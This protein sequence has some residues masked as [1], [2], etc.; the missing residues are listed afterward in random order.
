M[1]E[2]TWKQAIETVLSAEHEPLHYKAIAE[3]IGE[4]GLKATLGATPAATVGAQ[5]YTSIKDPLSPFEQVG[6]AFFRLKSNSY[7]THPVE[8]VDA[9]DVVS[10]TGAIRAFGMFW[11]RDLVIW[12][13]KA[14]LLGRQQVGAMTVDFAE[15]IGVY[16]LHDRERVIYVGRASEAISKRLKEHTTDRLSGRWDRFSWFGLRGVLENGSGLSDAAVSWNHEVVINTLEAILIESLEP[17]LNRKQGDGFAATEYL[18]AEDPTLEQKKMKQ[19]LNELAKNS[20]VA[21]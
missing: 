13:G 8:S 11:R 10:E 14:R 9:E 18:Q 2:L 20:G 16:L 5:L 15:Q 19:L 3:K 7:Y 1:P 6:K 17:P 12:V 21:L 4:K